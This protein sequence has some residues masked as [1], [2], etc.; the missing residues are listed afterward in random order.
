VQQAYRLMPYLVITNAVSVVLLQYP[1]SRLIGRE[2]LLRW[3]VLGS[4]MF[5]IAM[6]GFMHARSPLAWVASMV[7][8]TVGEVIVV[9]AEYLFI[10]LIAPEAKRGSY[11]G[12][13]NM[14]DL[15][16][17][18]S[19][20]ACGAVLEHSQ[21]GNMFLMLAGCAIAGAM[22]YRAGALA[23]QGTMRARPAPAV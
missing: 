12:A 3:I 19:Q 2:H 8:F 4:A 21:P 9:P 10:D 17:A 15:G 5:V 14:A 11:Y 16:S 23:A 18:L 7:I 6:L 20:I 22:L 13:Q 1:I